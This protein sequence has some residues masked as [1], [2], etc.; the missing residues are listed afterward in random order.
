MNG[1]DYWNITVS[2]RKWQY[3]KFISENVSNFLH[4]ISPNYKATSVSPV[5][6]IPLHYDDVIMGV[7]ESQIT[8]LTSVYSTLYSSVDQSKHPSSASLA[9]VWG[10]HRGPV[11]SPHKCQSRGKCFHLMTSSC[12]WKAHHITCCISTMKLSNMLS[13][14]QHHKCQSGLNSFI[15]PS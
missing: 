6:I 9:F 3:E 7:M 11:N 14:L 1:L 8:S 12:C 4:V 15:K 10:I 2:W 5:V 13:Q